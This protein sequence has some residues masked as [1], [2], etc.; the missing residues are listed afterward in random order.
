MLGK[1]S[2]QGA[3]LDRNPHKSR[4]AFGP[5]PLNQPL[6]ICNNNLTMSDPNPL[7]PAS[8]PSAEQAGSVSEHPVTAYDLRDTTLVIANAAQERVWED[9]AVAQWSMPRGWSYEVR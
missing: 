3:T 2:S 1:G 5:S 8:T 9:R 7:A 6:F 4:R